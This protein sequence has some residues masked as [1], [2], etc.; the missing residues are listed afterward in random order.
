MQNVLNVLNG[1]Y[2]IN[3]VAITLQQTDKIFEIK[4]NKLIKH[5]IKK[6]IKAKQTCKELIV[7][8]KFQ[9]LFC[10]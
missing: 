8:N 4:M 10:N 7:T 2:F 9:L 3:H 5:E 6:R 1:N